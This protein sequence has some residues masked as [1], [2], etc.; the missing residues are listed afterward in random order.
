M[1]T[2]HAPDTAH[3]Y[4]DAARDLATANPATA[5]GLAVVALMAVCWIARDYI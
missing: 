2:I 5:Y 4:L 1:K 3:A